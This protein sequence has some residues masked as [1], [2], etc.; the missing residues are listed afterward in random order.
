MFLSAV[1]DVGLVI[2]LCSLLFGVVIIIVH[3]L[4]TS[5]CS[6]LLILPVFVVVVLCS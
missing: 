3:V 4:C 1:F 6:L 5:S 2:V